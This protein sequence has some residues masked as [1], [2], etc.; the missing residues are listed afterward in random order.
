[1]YQL[2]ERPAR[3]Q[4]FTPLYA[5]RIFWLAQIVPFL[6]LLGFIGWKIRQSRL[7][8]REAQRIAALHNEAAELVRKLRRDDASPQ[9]YFSQATRAV[10]VKTALARNVDPNMVDAETAAATFQLDES[11]RDQLRRLF[12]RSDELRYSGARN[13][14]ETISAENRREVLD[15]VES[16]RT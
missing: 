15:L 13:G 4:S 12:E 3:A 9:T 5:R 2:T 14:A 7:D 16:L 10:Q 8:D 1:M 11:L 6:V